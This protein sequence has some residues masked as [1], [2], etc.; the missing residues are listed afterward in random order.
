MSFSVREKYA[1]LAA[2]IKSALLTLSQSKTYSV[3]GLVSLIFRLRVAKVYSIGLSAG[4]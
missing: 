3:M 4:L 2:L 1:C